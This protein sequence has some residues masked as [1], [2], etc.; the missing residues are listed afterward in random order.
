MLLDGFLHLFHRA[1]EVALA[2]CAAL[3]VAHGEE[4]QH[5]GEVVLVALLFL[6]STV[7]IGQ[8]PVVV[9]VVFGVK[10]LPEAAP[11]RILMR[12]T[13]RH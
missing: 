4:W 8:R 11:G 2:Q 3:L 6:Q 13:G 10:R 9:C 5:F 1:F 12:R 7:G